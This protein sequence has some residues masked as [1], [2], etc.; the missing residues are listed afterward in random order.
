MKGLELPINIIIVIAIAV[1]VLVVISAF[2]AGQF[3]GGVNTI[4]LETAFNNAC[5]TW[6]NVYNCDIGSVSWT[7]AGFKMPGTQNTANF[8]D[9]C[10]LKGADTLET[11]Q[12]LCGCPGTTGTGGASGRR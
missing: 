6:R 3:G 1:L 11:C 10:T 7:V 4:Q 12:Q 9:L 2:F 8:N 5:S